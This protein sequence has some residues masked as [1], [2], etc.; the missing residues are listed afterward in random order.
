MPALS[1]IT[2]HVKVG[3]VEYGFSKWKLSFRNNIPNVSSFKSAGYH[4]NV[5]GKAMATLTLT[6]PYDGAMP[7]V[8]GNVYEFHCGFTD[9][10]ELIVNARVGELTPANDY[11]DRPTLDVTAESNGPITPQVT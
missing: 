7:L 9:T 8:A 11:E 1:G 6:G 10:L 5:P 3:L 2:G 4:D